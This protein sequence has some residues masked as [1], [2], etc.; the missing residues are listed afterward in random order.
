[1]NDARF[2]GGTLPQC[3]LLADY[4][5]ND[6]NTESLKS[7]RKERFEMI[8]VEDR[9][10]NDPSWASLDTA[11]SQVKMEV[12]EMVMGHLLAECVDILNSIYIR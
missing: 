9:D 5:I 1:M 11:T 12:S 2:F 6:V 8:L 10:L 7:L 4:N 3:E